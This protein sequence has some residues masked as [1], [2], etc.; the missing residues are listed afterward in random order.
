MLSFAGGYRS[1]VAVAPQTWSGAISDLILAVGKDSCD[2]ARYNVQYL[3]FS[4]MDDDCEGYTSI[5][6]PR[7]RGSI[8]A[9][10]SGMKGKVGKLQFRF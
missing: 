8:S 5:S 3:I 4:A 2:Y 7:E 9:F 1:S 6:F 10:A